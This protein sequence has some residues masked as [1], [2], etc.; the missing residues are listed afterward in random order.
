MDHSTGKKYHKWNLFN[1]STVSHKA[2]SKRRTLLLHY[3]YRAKIMKKII[4]KHKRI[5][6][7]THIESQQT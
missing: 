1:I 7:T 4:K 6:Q 2:M 3:F 5:K